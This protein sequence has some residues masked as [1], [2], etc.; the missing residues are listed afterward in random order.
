MQITMRRPARGEAR[1]ADPARDE[2]GDLIAAVAGRRDRAAF[3]RL[4]ERHQTALFNLACYLSGNRDAAEETVQEAMLIVW[5]KADRFEYLGPGSVRAWMMRLTA[6][7]GL[8]QRHRRAQNARL[9]ERARARPDAAEPSGPD[10]KAERGELLA[11]LRGKLDE[12][13]GVERDVVALYYG[14]GLDQKAIAAHLD[15]SQQVVSYKLKQI[16]ERLRDGL[17][18]GGFAAALPLLDAADLGG[19]LHGGVAAPLGFA[20]R[21]AFSVARESV[22]SMRVAAVGGATYAALAVLLL[23]GT[24]G[25]VVWFTRNPPQQA[26]D[27]DG[28]RAAEKAELPVGAPEAAAASEPL[29]PYRVEWDFRER[30]APEAFQVLMGTWTWKGPKGKWPGGMEGATPKEVIVVRLPATPPHRPLRLRLHSRSVGATSQ[31]TAAGWLNETTAPMNYFKR[32][33]NLPFRVG[34]PTVHEYLFVDRLVVCSRDGE[35][36]SSRQ[37]DG[38]YSGDGI[39]LHFVNHHVERIELEGIGAA[40][41]EAFMKAHPEPFKSGEFK[42]FKDLPHA[43]TDFESGTLPDK[44]QE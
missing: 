7:E 26:P 43:Y 41:V 40:E 5:S 19:A 4:I 23:L 8:R 12:L 2:D 37:Y 29:E 32:K 35:L 34:E 9:A 28:A 36:I 33:D 21:V 31:E 10:E 14:A 25:A 24:G 3:A 17:V 20:D 42:L 27:G 1:A 16:L 38:A 30:P 22:R 11:A 39:A 44:K 6:N 13:T 18:K 15:L